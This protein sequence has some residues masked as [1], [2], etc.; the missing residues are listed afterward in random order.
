VVERHVVIVTDAAKGRLK[1]KNLARGKAWGT[2]PTPVESAPVI[3]KY[4]NVPDDP[5]K[6]I[7]GV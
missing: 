4:V 6:G 1:L 2:G 5:T 7:I 3:F